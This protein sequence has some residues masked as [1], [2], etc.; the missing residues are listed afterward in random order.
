M[1]AYLKKT[2]AIPFEIEFVYKKGKEKSRFK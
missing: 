2:K 1:V